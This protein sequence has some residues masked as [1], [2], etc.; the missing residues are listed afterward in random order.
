MKPCPSNIVLI[1]S[2]Y[3]TRFIR[4]QSEMFNMDLRHKSHEIRF[5]K[6]VPG[7]QYFMTH[8]P[9][10]D[11]QECLNR[12]FEESHLKYRSSIIEPFAKLV[13]NI[14]PLTIST[15]NSILD[16]QQGSQFTSEYIYLNVVKKKFHPKYVFVSSLIKNINK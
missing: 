6:Y 1:C 15:K 5:I 12:S 3:E 8:G 14:Q 9:I 11:D 16:I 10:G 2:I 13:S 4:G 7:M